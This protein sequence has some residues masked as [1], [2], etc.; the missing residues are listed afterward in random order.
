MDPTI[1]LLTLVAAAGLLGLFLLKRLDKGNSYRLR[2]HRAMSFT[3]YGTCPHDPVS[4]TFYHGV[5]IRHTPL[6]Q[7]PYA[8][9]A[10][11]GKRHFSQ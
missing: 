5:P 7:M 11:Y 4:D 10:S 2:A 1:V 6:G 9:R 8:T 3:P